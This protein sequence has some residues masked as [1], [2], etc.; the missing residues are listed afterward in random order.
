MP[1]PIIIDL[2]KGW[3]TKEMDKLVDN[4]PMLDETTK[5]QMKAQNVLMGKIDECL[6]GGVW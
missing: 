5:K 6:K 3:D 2:S 4:L 1:E